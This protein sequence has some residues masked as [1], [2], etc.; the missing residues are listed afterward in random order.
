MHNQKTKPSDS[1]TSQYNYPH[2]FKTAYGPKV[3]VR[4]SF[5]TP[6]RTKQSFKTECDI[7]H[8]MARYQK[9][10]VIEFTQKHAP[11]YADCTGIEF[12]AGMEIITRAQALFNAL[13]STL[14]NRFHNDPGEFLDFV[15]DDKNL[16]EARELGLLR[17]EQKQATPLHAE[18]GTALHEPLRH[19]EG[20]AKGGQYREHTRAEKRA[21]MREAA[22]AA[23]RRAAGE[24]GADN[25]DP[26]GS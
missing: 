11:Q 15:H 8:I 19:P 6:G 3:S 9:T 23:G 5:P 24:T 20:H 4:L 25:E 7:N 17:P 10:G 13:P 26:K 2:Q 14:R 1:P 16:E 12:Q 22:Q 21:D 18:D